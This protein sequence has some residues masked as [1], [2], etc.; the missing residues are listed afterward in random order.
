MRQ[1]Q[2]HPAL[3]TS[4][5][6]TDSGS[7]AASY[8]KVLSQPKYQETDEPDANAQI[9]DWLSQWF[10][11]LGAEFG[12]LKYTQEMP[13]F[14]SLLMAVF[15]VLAL[16]GLLYTLV[17][18]TRRRQKWKD[19]QSLE[20]DQSLLAST[21]RRDEEELRQALAG[22]NWHVAW[23]AGWRQFLSQLEKGRLVETDRSRTNR[24]Y[25]S[26]LRAQT[27]PAPVLALLTRL[28]DSYD[29]FIYGRHAIVESDWTSFHQQLDEAALL[30]H[31]PESTSGRKQ[32]ALVV[33]RNGIYIRVLLVLIALVVLLAFV[34]RSPRQSRSDLW[35][36]SSLNPVGAGHMAFYET[37][38]DLHWPVTRWR[39]PFS[40]LSSEGTGNVLI[41]TRSPV[42]ARVSFS[43]EET[44]LLSNG[45]AGATRFFCS[46]LSPNG[47]IPANCCATWVFNLPINAAA[48]SFADFFHPLE[49]RSSQEMRVPVSLTLGIPETLVLPPTTPLPLPLPPHTTILAQQNG[50]PYLLEVPHGSGKV[51]YGASA[52][53][54]SNSYLRRGDNLAV[55]LHLLAPAG[56]VP[57]HLLFE[58]SHHGFSAVFALARLLDQ[59]GV[60][61]GGML[62]LLGLLTFLGSSFIRFG[63]VIPLQSAAGRSTLEFVDSIADLYQRADLRNEM[64]GYL[65]RETHQRV[66]QRLHLPATAPHDLIATRLERAFPDLPRWKKLAQRFNSRDYTDGL[67][68]SGWLRV[69]RELIQIKSAMA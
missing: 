31:L 4:V 53:W 46:A 54:L 23:L 25:L 60:Q 20:A 2:P 17:R 15:V 9:R 3:D 33:T 66:L 51:I 11:R 50:Q 6:I 18:L 52:Q 45:S 5:P 28:I 1:H 26:Q 47:T 7:I 55:L 62:T 10:T 61:F 43:S 58:E 63:P 27:L 19:S 68:P 56:Q 36:P 13:R 21:P 64:I 22:G 32:G 41:I 29:S 40:R 12:Q 38:Q 59:P 16:I 49:N 34:S 39:E 44:D 42:G 67:P 14:A 57:S 35:L 48:T 65:F 24:E 69:A 37:L 8:Q 30:L